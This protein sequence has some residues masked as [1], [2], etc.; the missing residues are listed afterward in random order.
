MISTLNMKVR[1]YWEL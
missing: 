1:C